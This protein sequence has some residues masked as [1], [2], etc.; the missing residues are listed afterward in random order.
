[1]FKL[2]YKIGKYK[3]ATTFL[4]LLLVALFCFETNLHAQTA[5]ALAKCTIEN[6]GKRSCKTCTTVNGKE[7]CSYKNPVARSTDMNCMKQKTDANCPLSLV[8]LASMGT[9]T[10]VEDTCQ[11][12]GRY[13]Y[14]MDI[15]V[16]KG[17]PVVAAK[18]GYRV[19][20][21]GGCSEGAGQYIRIWHKTDP[22]PSKTAA[23]Q[24][25]VKSEN[26]D[27][28][29]TRYMHLH[30]YA[31]SSKSG[32]NRETVILGGEKIGYVG[33]TG[34]KGH[35][36]GNGTCSEYG[37]GAHLHYEV[38]ACANSCGKGSTID[39]SCPTLCDKEKST[40]P[41]WTMNTG[42]SWG[43]TNTSSSTSSGFNVNDCRDCENGKCNV[44]TVTSSNTI[45]HAN[46]S[47]SSSTTS[48]SVQGNSVT[49]ISSPAVNCKLSNYR[50]SLKDCIFC[51]LFEAIFNTAS[52]MCA[53]AAKA[54]SPSVILVM[55]VGTAIWIAF[56]LLKHLSSFEVK[57]ANRMLKE[58]LNKLFIVLFIFV[59]LKLDIEYLFSL[60]LEP[61]FNTGMALAQAIMGSNS[62]SASE[63]SIVA[64]GT[65]GTGGLPQS[66]GVSIL[67]TIKA[68][69]DRLLDVMALGS[70]FLCVAF[71]EKAWHLPI[72]P[73]LG[74]LFAGL[75]FWIAAIMFIVI[76]PWLLID[77]ILKLAV[78]VAIL[79]AALG[80]FAFKVTN[81]YFKKVWEQFMNAM[82]Q[83]IFLTIIIYILTAM[84]GTI[85]QDT[86]SALEKTS[87]STPLG[88][89]LS[90]LG[91]WSENFLKIVFVI[92]LGWAVLGES[93]GLGSQFGGGGMK[94][95][96][97]IGRKIGTQA[98]QGVKTVGLGSLSLAWKGSKA[99][100][101]A[102]GR[103]LGQTGNA[104]RQRVQA[105]RI[106]N[107]KNATTDA[108]G[109]T[110]YT[111]RNWR[112]RNVTR[113]LSVGANGNQLITKTVVGKNKTTIT[114]SD[115]HMTTKTVTNKNGE[116]IRKE[117]QMNSAE[118]K[119]LLNKDGSLHQ[120][121]I[122]NLMQNS[123]HNQE[124]ILIG[125]MNQ[126]MKERHGDNK[127]LQIA[128]KF[129][130]RSVQT[131]VDKNG[132]K[133]LTLSQRNSD[134][135]VQNFNMTL[136]QNRVLTS[137]ENIRGRNVQSFASD[138]IINKVT[139]S[140]LDKNGQLIKKSV[141]EKFSTSSYYGKNTLNSLGEFTSDVPKDDILFDQSELNK[142][143]DQVAN[144][145]SAEA[146]NTFL[147]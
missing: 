65:G 15:A 71:F 132:N 83:F 17:T 7:D 109:N 70:Y 26:D 27:C 36:L 146:D 46:I 66:M 63:F 118:L 102:V 89:F 51:G 95:S 14:G 101:R 114:Q 57:D 18:D 52:V 124:D 85:I 8:P 117:T 105:N 40:T 119:Y 47:Y 93:E 72:F 104:I 74:F 97:S 106:K 73:H 4:G 16:V 30:S 91:I 2:R 141:K 103:G 62:C 121:A 129:S 48:T 23:E 96:G 1:M 32:K 87:D 76:Y 50:S 82:F 131:G 126:V 138:G 58:I 3:K 120:V 78:V 122:N 77:T 34:L 127:N 86:L 135:L 140:K 53:H 112:G 56:T 130:S 88:D 29:C 64:S 5:E 94:F 75:G 90:S 61:I 35:S 107:N 113:T 134:G 108:N 21:L 125:L 25:I 24:P 133:T 68:I 9:A 20:L 43:A 81:S 92:F 84:L 59:L 44:P 41:S 6:Q 111:K 38:I 99:T 13:H 137:V 19:D 144:V 79:P 12:D 143:T 128:T 116:V 31:T 110:S 33:G 69:Q 100:G 42:T 10:M 136:S 80:G 123:M 145:G 39:T 45:P 37:Y 11:R 98:A 60:T 115:K 49:T 55:L 54:L 139:K 142:Y 147:R 28:F 67:C 22:S